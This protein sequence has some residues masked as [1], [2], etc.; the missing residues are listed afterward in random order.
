MLCAVFDFGD[1]SIDICLKMYCIVS[2][3]L[4]VYYVFF[5]WQVSCPTVVWP[6]LWTYKMICMYVCTC[7]WKILY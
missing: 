5:S 2:F 3:V 7:W 1:C 6:N 4:F